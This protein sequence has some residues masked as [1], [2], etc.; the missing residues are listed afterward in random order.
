MWKLLVIGWTICPSQADFNQSDQ[1]FA[2]SNSY[3]SE[4]HLF[5]SRKKTSVSFVALISVQ[6]KFSLEFNTWMQDSTWS[7]GSGKLNKDPGFNV[8]LCN[9]MMMT[10]DSKPEKR[11]TH[12]FTLKIRRKFCTQRGFTK[13]CEADLS[14][15]VTICFPLLINTSWG[16]WS[17]QVVATFVLCT[18][19][20]LL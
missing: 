9:Y 16:L 14:Y 3:W 18:N 20:N 19:T 6:H 2:E 4:K 8:L 13:Q 7:R 11:S 12:T 5:S 15:I 17:L 1:M 10:S